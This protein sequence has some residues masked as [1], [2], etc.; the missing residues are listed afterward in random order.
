[1]T[2]TE[3]VA[4]SATRIRQQR[5]VLLPVARRVRERT[6]LVER[7]RER[8]AIASFRSEPEVAEHLALADARGPL[9]GARPAAPHDPP[10]RNLTSQPSRSGWFPWMVIVRSSTRARRS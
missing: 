8:R 4:E 6:H 5:E 9:G 10:L 1:L 7:Q 2:H 3:P